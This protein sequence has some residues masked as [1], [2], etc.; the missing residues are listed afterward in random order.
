MRL[1]GKRVTVAAVAALCIALVAGVMI[2]RVPQ[3]TAQQAA[4]VYFATTNTPAGNVD[5]SRPAGVTALKT[6]L[7]DYVVTFP[8]PAS[9]LTNC[10]FVATTISAPG[11]QSTT[12]SARQ[13]A[14]ARV[15]V[16]TFNPAGAPQDLPF[17]LVVAC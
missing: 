3:A 10:A 13:V 14:A 9:N 7:G 16:F 11:G 1:T 17:N 15:G 4:T 5:A 2:S 12:A 6:G 8:A